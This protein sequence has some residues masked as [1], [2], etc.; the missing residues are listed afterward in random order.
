MEIEYDHVKVESKWQKRW[1]ESKIF[2]SDRID[3]ME[4]F[5]GNFPIPYVNGA[6]HLGHGYSAMKLE[7]VIRYQRMLGKNTVWPFGFHATGEPIAGMAKRVREKNENQLRVLKLSGI[8][9]EKFVEFEDPY[10]II[11]YFMQRS[12]ESFSSLGLAIDWRRQFVTTE[13]SPVFSKFIEW[14]YRILVDMGYVVKGSHP[15]I[16][17]PSCKSPTGDH[18]R[19]EGEGVR[20]VDFLLYKFYSED[21]DAY[22][23]P[24]TLR[25]ETVF[26]VTNVF[27]H[28]DVTYVVAKVNDDRL[29]MAEEAVVKFMD[30]KFKVKVVE[31][32]DAKDLFGKMVVNPMTGNKVP[33]LPGY[34]IDAQG[35]TGVVMSVPAHAPVDWATLMDIKTN[36]TQMEKFGVSKELIES[37]EPISLITL[38]GYS[39]FPAKDAVEEFGVK[40]QKDEKLKEATKLVYRKEF[41]HGI[42]KEITGKYAGKL[43]SEIK[44]QLSED[45]V[46]E[47]K[48]LVLKEPSGVVICRCGTRNHV[49]FLPEQWFL[50]FS[51][52]EWKAKVHRLV[53]TMNV[54]PE[55]ARAN[56]KN[57]IDWLEDKACVRQS[58]LGTPAPWDP[59]WI[60]ETLG[61]SVIYMAFYL[62]APYVNSGEF[63][64]EWAVDEVFSYIF[65]KKGN[66]KKISSEVGIPYNLLRKIQK[67]MDYWYGFDLRSSGKDLIQNHLTFMLF[68]HC[69]IFPEKYWPKGVHV[70]GYVNIQ[71]KNAANEIVEE[72]M[73]KSKGN[74]KT[75]DDIVGT[76]GADATRLGFLI[77]GEG[78]N[79]ASFAVD[80]VDSY[81][82]WMIHLYELIKDD[83][84]DDEV[85]QIDRWLIS[86]LQDQ[87]RKVR[88]HLDRVETRSA[89]Q[90][91]YHETL[92]LLRWYQ[93]RRGSKG[94]AYRQ[95]LETML[96]LIVPFIPHFC[97]EVWES[98]G[99]TG[100]ISNESYPDYDETKFDE[101]A[102][103]S[104]KFL[105]ELVDSI[106]N[107]YSFLIDKKGESKPSKIEIFV[108]PPWKYLMYD[109]ARKDIRTLMKNAM[110]IPEVKKNGKAAA[111]YG[112]FLMKQ[113]GPPDMEWS[114]ELENQTLHQ[115]REY[116]ERTFETK[117]VVLP[118]DESDHP[119]AK[120]AV[121]R[122]P[123]VNFIK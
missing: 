107:L 89:F 26:G 82:K 69:A 45:I 74:F 9:E 28:P 23:V 63:K 119:K 80:E 20:I 64:E 72:K 42:T 73:S 106:R 41:N 70:N 61:D 84:D 85:Q 62:V 29:V 40:D 118:A 36:P 50:K 47:G 52:K 113:G 59:K 88:N 78:L 44:D 101:E 117:V 15:V 115:S 108:S 51:D 14:Q 3:G 54:Y 25:P 17:C 87:I 105:G 34:F 109:E 96:K 53:D 37:I 4:K 38:E 123:G 100:F 27:L 18:D 13:L 77:A 98:L 79:D 114:L 55:A 116:L 68:H 31:K 57:T 6:M 121:P 71:K 67:D 8:P 1:A 94:P 65:L 49:K 86:K 66:A 10:N 32:L 2:E 112:K 11:R 95:T 30:Q 5:F 104:E 93:N 103:R 22:F 7:A 60:I 91:A 75:L 90:V 19:L 16:W 24:G 12:K 39:E 92:Q 58:G 76:F 46:N 110:Q 48:A 120:S 102:E 35:A 83:I 43:V 81:S 56:F 33:L 122:R 111:N 97:E 21:L 99:N